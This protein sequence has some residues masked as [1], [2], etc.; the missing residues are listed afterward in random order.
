[1]GNIDG[2]GY[3]LSA[4]ALAAA[5]PAL[6]PGAAFSHD[7]LNFTWPDVPAG[8]PDNVVASGQTIEVSGSGSKLGLVGLGISGAASGPVTVTYTDGTTQTAAVNFADWYSNKAAAG[9]SIVTSFAYHNTATVKRVRQVSLYYASVPVDPAKTV[10]YVTLPNVSQG[11]A[12]A[13]I[14]LHIFTTSIG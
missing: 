1:V 2:G 7:G 4:Q 3:S 11:V 5:T 6:T 13:T 8:T 12:A 14:S 9:G 10:R